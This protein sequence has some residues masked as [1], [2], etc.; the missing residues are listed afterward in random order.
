MA[1]L[2][3]PDSLLVFVV[4]LLFIS[5]RLDTRIA[6]KSGKWV[7]RE[8]NEC[9]HIV[10]KRR[11]LLYLK[12]IKNRLRQLDENYMVSQTL[13]L[14]EIDAFIDV[15]ANIG[16]LSKLHELPYFGFEPGA[17]EFAC[18][19]LN[20]P[21]S[22]GTVNIGLWYEETALTFY[23]ASST[24]DSSFIEPQNY[25]N[26]YHMNVRRL[27]SYDIPA[28]VFLKVEAEGAEI[29]VLQG[30]EKILSRVSCIAVDTGFERGV[31]CESTTVEV[32]DFLYSRN[33]RLVNLTANRL[34]LL[35][36]REDLIDRKA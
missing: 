25:D 12:G 31:D 34:I 5:R 23:E 3:L 16:E 26:S 13:D 9:L 21:K 8:N 32:V 28:N 7:V 19:Q 2:T 22:S 11:V 30:A 10:H 35:F 27:D 24:A 18:L 1:A 33:F 4:N 14:L 20:V 15:G 17:E 36:Y 6:K 29:E